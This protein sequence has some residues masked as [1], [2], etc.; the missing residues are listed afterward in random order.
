MLAVCDGTDAVLLPAAQDFKRAFDGDAGPNTGGMGAY[1]PVPGVDVDA[2][3]IAGAIHR[4]RRSTRC[5][6]ATSTTA[7]CCTPG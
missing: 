3:D 5:A 2:L 1:S 6:S 7:A 4:A